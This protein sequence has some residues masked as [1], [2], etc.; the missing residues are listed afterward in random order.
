MTHTLTTAID[1]ADTAVSGPRLRAVDYLRVSTEE[2]AKGYGIAY[3]GKKTSRYIQRKGWRHVGTYAD[4]GVS[5]SLEAHE[6][7]DLKR[8]MENVREDPRPFDVVVVAEGRA[9]GRTGRAFWRWVWELKDLG[10]YVAVVKGDY[11]NTT[12]DGRKK[13]R[14]DADYAEEE[15]EVIRDRTQGGLQ[16][17]A[18]EGGY[19]GGNVPYGW[20]IE[21]QGKKGESRLVLDIHE[22]D[23][24]IKGETI[25]LRRARAL[26][27]AEGMN[28]GEAAGQ[29]NL[30]GFLTRSDV[31]WSRDNLKARLMSRAVLEG[32]Q[33]F[34]DPRSAASPTGRGTKLGRDGKPIYGSTVTIKLDQPF[35]EEETKELVNAAK[36]LS[37]RRSPK[38][39]SEIYPLSGVIKSLCGGRYVGTIQSATGV[40]TYVCSGK[41]EKYV[42]AGTCSC[43]QIDA[44]RIEA[45]VWGRA[46]R[47]LGDPEELRGLAAESVDMTLGAQG[48]HE[49]RIEELDGQIAVQQKAIATVMRSTSLQAAAMDMSDEEIQELLAQAVG[50]LRDEVGRLKKLRQEAVDWQRETEEAEQLARDMRAL[51]EMAHVE[52]PNMPPESKAE[53]VDLADIKVTILSPVPLRKAR[54]EC[55]VGAWFKAGGLGIPVEVSDERWAQIE[56]LVKKTGRG[57]GKA[58]DLPLR[59]CVEAVLRKARDAV[60]WNTAAGSL[61]R[62]NGRSLMKRWLRW[63]EDGSWARVVAAL[64]GVESLP[65]PEPSN[66]IPLPD[67]LVEG[68]LDPRLLLGHSEAD[69]QTRASTPTIR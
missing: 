30:E 47:I 7:D 57:S 51:A 4:E 2:Q 11:D 17:K 25:T 49:E 22:G 28:W 39:N 27:A 40:R 15:R 58:T 48:G 26:I 60:S 16:E 52:M 38:S 64:E 1:V 20:R 33:V 37:K 54:T 50:P 14:K 8:L 43:S 13:M 46:T 9:I 34:R 24:F 45:E 3:T 23:G 67:L 29:L 31:P 19:T 18:E 6:R 10:V 55:S 62:G 59:E 61:S 56:P 5:G 32:I 68:R 66:E 42:G 36:K 63:E 44:D 35:T 69:D 41:Q 21:D 12:A 53:F 65:V